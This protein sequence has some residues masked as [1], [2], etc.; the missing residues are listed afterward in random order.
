MSNVRSSFLL[1]F[2]EKYIVLILNIISTVVLARLMTP[3]ETGLFSVASGLINLAQTLRDFGAA[4]YVLQ[5]KELTRDRLATALGIA[6]GI[7]L[8]FGGGFALA[9]GSIADFFN[10]PR[11]QQVVTVLSLN[12]V[13]V[14]FA[15]IGSAKLRRAMNFKALLRINIVSAFVYSGTA[16]LLAYLGYGAYGLAWASFLGVFAVIIGTYIYYP[17]DIFLIPTLKEW[18]Y[19]YKFG[20]F[21]GGGQVLQGLSDRAP[22][23][24]IGRLL[25]FET[26]A[27]YSRGNGL[28]TLFQ[29]ALVS[30]VS[31]V[32]ISALA[33][34]HRE[35]Q[36]LRLPFLRGLG[37]LTGVAWPFLAMLGLMAYPMIRVLFGEQWLPAV[38]VAQI[39]C[40]GAGFGI[41]GH[42]CFLVFNASGTVRQYFFIQSVAVPIQVAGVVGGA[43]HS[44]EAAAWGMVF[45]LA[46]LGWLSLR[47]VNR[48]LGTTWRQLSGAMSKSAAVTLATGILPALLV[49]RPGFA[50]SFWASTLAAGTGGL[51]SWLAALFLVRHPLSE[52]LAL[53]ATGL[54]RRLVQSRA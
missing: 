32:I 24:A 48:T 25:G 34:L 54:R 10:E 21:A 28:I 2:V 22:D 43:F 23:I 15:S 30:A 38:P 51:L 50:D 8:V 36:D 47:G 6:I 27:M 42:L 9:A 49:L 14:A 45:G 7:G 33:K 1:S 19:I 12:L 29:Q 16:I 18:R 4:N 13:A 41:L 35:D 20:L 40:F 39:L 3:A 53:A 37:H 17:R 52:E 26:A 46:V 11:L 44:V 5:E 31:P